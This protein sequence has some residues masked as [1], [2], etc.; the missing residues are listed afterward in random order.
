MTN[1][2]KILNITVKEMQIKTI[3]KYHSTPVR[4]ATINKAQTTNIG[5]YMEKREPSCTVSGNEVGAAT[6]ENSMEGPKK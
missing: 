1:K 6:K 3:V 5:K 2:Y 4:T